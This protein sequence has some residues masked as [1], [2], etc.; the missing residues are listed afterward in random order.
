MLIRLIVFLFFRFLV[1]DSP[2]PTR[3]FGRPLHRPESQPVMVMGLIIFVP[4]LPTLTRDFGVRGHLGSRTLTRDFGVDVVAEIKSF[5]TEDVFFCAFFPKS[6]LPRAQKSLAE[7]A[8]SSGDLWHF[9]GAG[10]GL[11]LLESR[12]RL[13]AARWLKKSVHLPRFARKM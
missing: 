4:N 1:T 9:R 3:D 5:F 8:D 11:Y 6:C 10:S 2:T 13:R 7:I 12:R